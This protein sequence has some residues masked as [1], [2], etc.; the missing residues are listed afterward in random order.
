MPF[1]LVSKLV[2]VPA[3]ESVST[4]ALNLARASELASASDPQSSS[5][6]TPALGSAA[7]SAPRAPEWYRAVVQACT[8]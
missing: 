2:S 5:D 6:Q 1:E 8:A 4:P 7:A 3:L